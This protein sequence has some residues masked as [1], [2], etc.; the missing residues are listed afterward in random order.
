M[1]R[2]YTL[3][4]GSGGN[5][6]FIEAAGKRILIDAGKNAKA[7]CSALC[8]IGS[9]ISE[10]EAI[11]ITHEHTDHISALEVISKKHSIPIHIMTKSAAKIDRCKDSFASRCLVRH[12]DE[13]EVSLGDLSMRAFKTPHD[14]LMSVGFRIDYTDA[15]G[16]HSIG[17]ATDIGYVTETISA[18]L[19][20]CEAVVLESN[21]DVEMLKNGSYPFDL[22]KRILSQRG[23]LSNKDSA[24]FAA[25]L[26]ANGT[27]AFLLAHLSEENNTPDTALD[28]YTSA[29]A[30]PS[31]FIDV[32]SPDTP[33][34]LHIPKKENM[35]YAFGEDNNCGNA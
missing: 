8:E 32:A 5:S 4:S 30:D 26:A 21:H 34:Q 11:F 2:I 12:D 1:S 29:I 31:I 25:Y 22:K 20:G 23:H 15:D 35:T 6:T 7:L 3:Y 33:T 10:I 9:D 13:Y 28:E 16:P 17:L 19:V 18:S 27:R 14:S 24:E